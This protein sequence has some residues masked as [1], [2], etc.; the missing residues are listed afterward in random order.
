MDG[1]Q[2][3]GPRTTLEQALAENERLRKLLEEY[4]ELVSAIRAQRVDAFVVESRSGKRVYAIEGA[5]RCFRTLIETIQQGALTLDR[6]GL[7][8]FANSRAAAM[9]GRQR[10]QIVGTKLVEHVDE[11][12]RETFEA[13]LRSAPS[14]APLR[15]L[16]RDRGRVPVRLSLEVLGIESGATFGAIVTEL[17]DP[18]EREHA[19]AAEDLARSILEQAQDAIVVCD[20]HG[21]VLRCNEAARELC[22]CNPL[23]ARF[24][25]VFPLHWSDPAH[26]PFATALA[27]PQRGI[28]ARLLR[29]GIAPVDVLVS[30]GPLRRP[31]GEVAGI[32]LTL[33]DLSEQQQLLASERAARAEAER[34]NRLKDDFVATLSH[35]LRTPLNAILGW[36]HL[37]RSRGSVGP[38]V[39]EG[40]EVIERNGRAQ[41][42][43]ISDLLDTSRMLSGKLRLELQTAEPAEIVETAIQGAVPAANAKDLRIER[44]LERVGPITCDPGRL[45][46]VVANLL[47]NSV[48]FTPS[49]GSIDVTLRRAGD[50]LELAIR[51]T[52]RGIAPE[53]LPHLFE[54]FRQGDVG[55]TRRAGGLGLGLSIAKQIVDLHGGTISAASPGPGG[56]A[57]FTVRIPLATRLAREAGTPAVAPVLD[58]HSFDDRRVLMVDDERDARE[59][60]KRV[61]EEYGAEVVTA[62]SVDEALELLP[63]ARPDLIVSD[64]GMPDRDGYELLRAVRS[65]GPE[66][67]GDV[68]AIALT[69]F[70]RAEDR[71]RALHAGYS[72]HVPKPIDVAELV[73]AVATLVRD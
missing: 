59:L 8:L 4:E 2:E 68:P 52:G 32:V 70:A 20:P 18:L 31:D 15:L 50:E 36:A 24:E 63:K 47:Q 60:V 5:D 42:K 62:G 11:A 34:A 1:E 46:Q 27:T 33:V 22:D 14:I 3:T 58:A 66:R 56:G 6:D 39:D 44:R 53:F 55:P 45:Q 57:T 30:A 71:M 61:L 21:T 19:I 9:L 10:S 43:L 25:D 26:S 29:D 38:L 12:D 40:I 73:S 41:A 16:A 7:I 67:G 37:L 64:I 51:D 72:A 23:H 69:A 65:L 49:G 13:L 28:K 35:E 17:A 48:K 54:R